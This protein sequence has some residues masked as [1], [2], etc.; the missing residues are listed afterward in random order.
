MNFNFLTYFSLSLFIENCSFS[1]K[2]ILLQ[3]SKIFIGLRLDLIKRNFKLHNIIF[4]IQ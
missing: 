3:N 2:N 1:I 4:S